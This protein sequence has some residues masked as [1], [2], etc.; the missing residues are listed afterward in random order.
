VL[1]QFVIEAIVLSLLG[2]FA[3]IMLGG[4][5]A[6]AL[7]KVITTQIEAWSVVMA[8][9]FS[10]GIGVFFGVYPAMKASRLDPIVALRHE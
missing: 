7:S 10:V 6:L 5:G 8:L 9:V 2:G 1:S 4:G 3:G